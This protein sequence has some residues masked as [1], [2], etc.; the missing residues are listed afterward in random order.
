[1]SNIISSNSFLSDLSKALRNG[2][3]SAFSIPR[4]ILKEGI[5]LS[6][7]IKVQRLH[8]WE[9]ALEGERERERRALDII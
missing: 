2:F 3:H 7:I 1:M 8:K 6:I 5:V 4:V 9:L